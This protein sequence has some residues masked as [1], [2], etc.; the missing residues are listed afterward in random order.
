[1]IGDITA[2]SEIYIVTGYTDY[3]KYADAIY[4]SVMFQLISLKFQ[5]VALWI[6]CPLM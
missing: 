5:P 1:M 2:A 4:I 3:P 6:L